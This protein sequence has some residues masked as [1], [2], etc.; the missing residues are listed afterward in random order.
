MP[1]ATPTRMLM[2]LRKLTWRSQD[3][4]GPARP[5]RR[6]TG[7]FASPAGA[8]LRPGRRPSRLQL[9]ALAR[10]PFPVVRLTSQAL[11]RAWPVCHTAL[12]PRREPVDCRA[13]TMLC[14]R[15]CGASSVPWLEPGGAFTPS[16]PSAGA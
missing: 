14:Q 1:T 11:A 12:A 13:A 7:G 6:L 2:R 3:S 15:F 10:P 5:R 9:A 8:L 16:S 4:G